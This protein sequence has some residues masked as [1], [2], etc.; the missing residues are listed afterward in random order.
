MTRETPPDGHLLNE[1]EWL[2]LRALADV[3]VPPSEKYGVP[4][5]GDEA[6]AKTIVKDAN[7]GDKL[8]RLIAALDTLNTMAQAAHRADFVL[9]HPG[10][11]E[12]V[13]QAFR[14]EEPAAATLAEQLV[15]Q[16]YYRDDRVV[17]SLGLELRPPMPEGYKVEQGDW[18]L[19]DKVR[20]R[21]PF[22]R[23]AG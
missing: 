12:A 6:I 18:S 11:R 5:A 1:T 22:H 20:Q 7:Y 19:L 15:T 8:A 13:A 4:G 14:E 16:C 21:Q 17:A 23:P 9:L 3:I 10:Q 2:T